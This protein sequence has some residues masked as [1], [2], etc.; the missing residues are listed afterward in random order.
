M[1]MVKRTLLAL[2][3]CLHRIVVLCHH[4]LRV[5][6]AVMMAMMMIVSSPNNDGRKAN[7]DV[8]EDNIN[9]YTASISGNDTGNV[10]EL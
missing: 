4:I 3:P 1:E 6:Q 7:A 10:A 2:G 8:K 5:L 9:V